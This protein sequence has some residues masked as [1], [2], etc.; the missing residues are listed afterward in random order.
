M[1]TCAQAVADID[2]DKA[3]VF[4]KIDA[5]KGYH[6]CPVDNESQMLTTIITPFGE[7]KFLHAPYGI[8]SIE[9]YNC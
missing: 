9:H 5:M 8:S 1:P 2:A 4:T 3:K 6:I 7:F